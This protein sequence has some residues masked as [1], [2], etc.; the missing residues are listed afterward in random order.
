MVLKAAWPWD[1]DSSVTKDK[2]AEPGRTP[3]YI[4]LQSSCGSVDLDRV[5]SHMFGG[6]GA[7]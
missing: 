4:F 5:F 1:S 3:L 2:L 6:E 7:T